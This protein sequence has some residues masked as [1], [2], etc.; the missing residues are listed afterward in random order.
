VIRL[1]TGGPVVGLLSNAA[2]LQDRVQLQVNDLF[3][4]FTD[5]ISEAMDSNDEEWGE[6]RM[7]EVLQRCVGND[8]GSV[9]NQLLWLL[10]VLSTALPTRRHDGFDDASSGQSLT[11]GPS[12]LRQNPNPTIAR[13]PRPQ[14]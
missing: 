2:Y 13:N 11:L 4:G 1:E 9:A 14:T 10:M 5:G 3:V 7:I 6:G 12:D 8:A